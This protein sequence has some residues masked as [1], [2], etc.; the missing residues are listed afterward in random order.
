MQ[1]VSNENIILS[2]SNTLYISDQ[3]SKPREIL[4]QKFERKLL[5]S[6]LK[7]RFKSAKRV[8][9][10]FLNYSTEAAYK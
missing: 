2:K 6:F 10:L 3:F 1:I 4:P 5:K 9:K 8:L 7:T